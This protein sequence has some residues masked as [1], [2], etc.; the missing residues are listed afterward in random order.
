[1]EKC[2]DRLVRLIVRRRAEALLPAFTGP[3]LALD[4]VLGSWLG[5]ALLRYNYPPK[6][7]KPS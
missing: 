3:L 2:V 1:V 5:N 4:R 7:E 6:L